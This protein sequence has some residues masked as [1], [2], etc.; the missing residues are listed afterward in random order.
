VATADF[1]HVMYYMPN[2]SGKDVGA[3]T[4]TSEQLRSFDQ[5][6]R[7]LETPNP[8]VIH[9]GPHGYMVQGRGVAE[10][11]AI[12]KEYQEMLARLCTI[13]KVWCLTESQAR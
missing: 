8:M 6:G 9:Q 5:H 4:P 1:S 7:W 11:A 12:T 10:N 3:A 13:K 2:V